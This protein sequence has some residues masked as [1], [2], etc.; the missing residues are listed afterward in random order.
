[1][2][3]TWLPLWLPIYLRIQDLAEVAANNLSSYLPLGMY[4]GTTRYY[5]SLDIERE[6]HDPF[7]KSAVSLPLYLLG[8]RLKIRVGIFIRQNEGCMCSIYYTVGKKVTINRG[9]TK[10]P[11]HTQQ[12]TITNIANMMPFIFISQWRQHNNRSASTTIE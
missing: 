5:H 6:C 3:T 10:C 7:I 8:M 12:Y 9:N 1:M 4:L 2:D 11:S